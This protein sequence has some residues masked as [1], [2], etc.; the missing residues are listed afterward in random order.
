MLWAKRLAIMATLSLTLMIPA[1]GFA[2]S[3]LDKANEGGLNAVGTTAYGES[4]APT[5]GITAIVASII[6]VF[7]GLLGIIFIVLLIVAG[8]KYMTAGGNEDQV[9]EAV[10]QIRNA[11]IGLLITICAYSITYFV[12]NTVIPKITNNN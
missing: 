10:G 9:H 4:G 7:L 8:F 2:A 5:K 6:K 1:F 12:T 11:V 3:W